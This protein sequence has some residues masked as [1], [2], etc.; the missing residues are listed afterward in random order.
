[1]KHDESEITAVADT[2]VEGESL[3]LLLE[4]MS[5]SSDFPAL[6]AA[7]T[8]IQHLV[9][10]ESENL[11]T[12]S[13]EIIKD[14]ALTQKLLRL[15]NTAHFSHAGAGG[16]GTVSR[17]VAL[18][19]FGGVR[20]LAMSL[21]LLEHMPDRA[22]AARLRHE[23]LR[24]L[25]SA[26]L[27]GELSMAG[28]VG[29]EAFVG[30]LFQSLGRLLT[31]AYLPAEADRIRA[32]S[33]SPAT[34][35]TAAKQVLGVTLQQLGLGVAR[36]WSLP[37]NLQRCMDTPVGDEPRRAAAAGSDRLRWLGRLSQELADTLLSTPAD[38]VPAAVQ[39]LAQRASPVL[40]IGVREI[41]AAA[42]RMRA[43]LPQWARALGLEGALN[44][45]PTQPAAQRRSDDPP[46][47]R[48]ASPAA[49]AA[50]ATTAP[51]A[52]PPGVAI[53]TAGTLDITEALLAEPLC[54]DIVVQVL[55]EAVFRALRARHVV[56]C[57]RD[58]ASGEL[59]GRHALGLNRGIA[60][61]AFHV[62][63]ATSARDPFALLCSNGA[64]T[65]IAD[66]GS[67]QIAARLPDWYRQHFAAGTFLLMPLMH[68]QRPLGLLYADKTLANSLAPNE[69]EWLLLRTLRNQALLALRLPAP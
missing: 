16:I 24:A 41:A 58:D 44:A 17:A 33:P 29:E 11:H 18:I 63:L 32:L 39:Q 25:L 46:V 30:T 8:R 19:G 5:H 59:V 45:A 38:K 9:S 60:A 64:D 26:S 40:D 69:R 37:E 7:V 65:L 1:M 28:D 62:P 43:G 48:A 13:G 52:E 49:P 66:A 4:R 3:A 22:Q 67:S 21:V 31:E 51:A 34:R 54:L 42:E 56:L 23:Y 55:I 10:S 53:L 61:A 35:D 47:A 57:L 36:S 27:A 6:S 14:V 2:Q 20:N 68:K 15:V 50:A 12:L